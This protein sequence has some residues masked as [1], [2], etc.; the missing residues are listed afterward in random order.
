MWDT[1]A[2][3]TVVD[4]SFVEAHSDLFTFEIVDDGLGDSSEE[5]TAIDS[6]GHDVALRPARMAACTIGG[7]VFGESPCATMDFEAIDGGGDDLPF[8]LALGFPLLTMAD[9]IIDTPAGTWSVL[10]R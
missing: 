4:S 6:T 2:S 3:L 9:W 7:V 8:R 10:S 5:L 1:G